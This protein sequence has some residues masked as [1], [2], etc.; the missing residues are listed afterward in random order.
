MTSIPR[1]DQTSPPNSPEGW[2]PGWRPVAYWS[3]RSTP[4]PP[5]LT[6]EETTVPTKLTPTP[7]DDQLVRNIMDINPSKPTKSL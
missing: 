7:P 6:H 4:V 5:G 1:A 2:E 3:Q